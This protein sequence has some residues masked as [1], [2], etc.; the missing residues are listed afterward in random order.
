MNFS[1]QKDILSIEFRDN[2]IRI[3]VGKVDKNKL[4]IKNNFSI[5]LPDNIY[6]DGKIID[7]SQLSY[8]LKRQLEI[9][10]VR[11]KNLHVILDTD[12]MIIREI[13]L[14]SV[15]EDNHERFLNYHLEDF[16]PIKMDE[17]IIEHMVVDSLFNHESTKLLIM[18]AP[19]KLIEEFHKLLLNLKLNP[20]VLDIVP[21]SISKFLSYNEEFE[22]VATIGIDYSRTNIIICNQGQLR[23]CRTLEVGYGKLLEHLKDLDLDRY[24]LLNILTDG[25]LNYDNEKHK[26]IIVANISFQSLIL[27]EIELVLKYYAEILPIRKI[28][29]YEE[30]CKTNN[31]EDVFSQYF[32]FQ[33]QRISVLDDLDFNGDLI[34]YANCIGGIIRL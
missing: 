19:K 27:R 20:L 25:N 1:R 21:N 17:Y 33:C 9:N 14:P 6:E 30:Y 23:Y 5:D 15:V 28:Y 18:A 26:R 12:K 34:Y 31:I 4:I 29:L 10:K 7:S 13:V 22:N 24:E 32:N 11:V 8:I 16:I 2:Q 3:V